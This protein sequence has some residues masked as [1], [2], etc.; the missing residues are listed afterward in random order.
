[1]NDT[2]KDYSAEPH[3][4]NLTYHHPKQQLAIRVE[5]GPE[6]SV[7]QVTLGELL[8]FDLP[9]TSGLSGGLWLSLREAEGL[10]KMVEYILGQV[11]TGKLRISQE[12]KTGLESVAPRLQA[13]MESLKGVEAPGAKEE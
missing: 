8:A 2:D 9:G 3:P 13:M 10:Y 7:D 11:R 12:S 5:A 1:M 6:I 4:V